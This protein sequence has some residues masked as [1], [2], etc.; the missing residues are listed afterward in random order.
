MRAALAAMI[1]VAG[2]VIGQREV[3]AP[4]TEEPTI[5]LLTCQLHHP[6]RDIARHAWFAV[7]DRGEQRWERIETGYC[8]SGPVGGLGDVI[9]HRVW[10]GDEVSEQIACL[11]AHADRNQPRDKYL[12]WPGPNSNTFVA[13]LLRRCDLRADLPATAIGKD[14]DGPVSAGLTTGGTGI[15]IETPLIG[16]RLGLTEGVQIHLLAFEIGIDWWP[17]AIIV[18]L[19]P[20]RVGFADR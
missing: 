10:S 4:E 14:F 6:L 11:R 18:P 3:K 8:G 17:P 5:L 1:L 15:Q 20:G 9:L 7:R 19:G 12:P 16:V 13:R 2:C